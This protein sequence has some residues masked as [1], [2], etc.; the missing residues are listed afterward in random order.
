[1][2]VAVL[3]NERFC[4]F[5]GQSSS[6][7][8][9]VWLL[10]GFQPKKVST[11]AIERILDAEDTSISN[12]RGYGV[13]TKG[14]LMYIINLTSCTLV[15]D[16]KEKVWHEWSTN[17]AGS[18][19]AFAYNYAADTGAG[20]DALLH[21]TDGYVYLLSPTTYQDNGTSIIAD[22]YTSKYDGSTMNRKFMHN[23]TVVG[24]QG[25]TYT[26]R[27]SDDDYTT[28]NTFKTLDTIRPWFARCGSFR[29]RAFVLGLLVVA[30]FVVEHSMSDTQLMK[31]LELKQLSLK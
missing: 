25:S 11:E 13:R 3:E 24:D 10:E 18:H 16:V 23:L 19:T 2:N 28:W 1:M 15:Y 12:A 5:V 29:R 21:N 14:H 26:I 20:Y 7:G 9:A 6:G 22:I 8:R 27:W 17:N 30:P 31:I 4:I